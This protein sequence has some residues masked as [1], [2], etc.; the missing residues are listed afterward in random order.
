[1]EKMAVELCPE[2]GLCSLVRASGSKAD[3]LPDEVQA[4]RDA[5]GDLAKIRDVVSTADAAFGSALTDDELREIVRN[6][7]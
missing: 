7:G 3:L 6:V 4:L 2:T 1:M 5:G